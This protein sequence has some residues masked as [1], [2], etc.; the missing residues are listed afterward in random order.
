MIHEICFCIPQ[1][2]FLHSLKYVV[3]ILQTFTLHAQKY[4]VYAERNSFKPL[5]VDELG[6]EVSTNLLDSVLDIAGGVCTVV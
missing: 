5:M 3:R 2:R 4:I 1:L 6:S